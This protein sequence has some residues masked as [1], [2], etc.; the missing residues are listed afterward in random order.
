MYKFHSRKLRK[1]AWSIV[2]TSALFA[3]AAGM[4]VPRGCGQTLNSAVAQDASGAP[5]RVTL[6]DALERARHNSVGFQ[7]AAGD[8]AIAR[9]DRTQARD[10][11]LP[12]VAYNNSGIYTQGGG[13]GFPVRFIANNAVHE[14]LSE[15]N[16]HETLGAAGFADL[17]KASALAAV[18]RA[19]A[20]IASRGLVVT[21][22]QSY[23]ATLAAQ[24]KLESSKRAAQEG[25]RFF[26]LTQDLEHGGEVAHSDVIKAELQANDRHRQMQEA[27]LAVLNA[28]LDLG[29]LLFQD[30]NNSFELADDLHASAP[31][32]TLGEVQQHAAKDNPDVRAAVSAA[33]AAGHE[34]AASR[35]GYLPTLG[36]DYFYGIDA[37]RFATRT[38]GAPNLG[39][40]IVVSLDIPIWNWGST[41]SKVKQSEVREKQAKLELSL[42]QRKLL[43]EIQSLY[44]EAETAQSQL[45]SLQR[46]AELAADSLR[47][48]TLRYQNGESTVLEVVDAQNSATLADAGY[49]DG[50]ARYRLALANLQT[51]TGVQT[52]P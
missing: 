45:A 34:V 12:S 44:A 46:S 19:K 48:T 6:Q 7:A 25:D 5:I 47:L 40:S 50:A 27:L 16:V 2:A 10:A 13:V 17:H 41:Q 26:K 29:V 32:P 14:Y 9:E 8:A 3:G 21:V 52:R 49:Q 1:L 37:S 28:R 24:A 18:A 15:G 51:L 35:A 38:D 4:L 11:L 22:T 30:F 23:Y 20:E 31:L 36:I 33:E 42:A 43:A 39:S